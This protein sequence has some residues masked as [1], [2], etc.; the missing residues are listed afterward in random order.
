MIANTMPDP[1]Q[2]YAIR[3]EGL[4]KSFKGDS[5]GDQMPWVFA[6]VVGVKN[7]ILPPPKRVVVDNVNL[8]VQTGEFFGVLGSNGA[9]KT[10]LLKLLACLLYPDAG[11]GTVN[12]YDILKE[13]MSVRRSVTISKAQGGLG[14]LWQL[15]GRENLLFRARMSGLSNK[16]A[17]RK[18]DYIIERLGL[19]RK[20]RSYS[21]ELSSGEVQKF[22]LAATFISSAPIVMLDEPT[23]HLDPRVAREVREFIK[24]DLNK[25]GG[26]TIIMSTHYL[27]EADL[28]CDRVALMR[29]GQILACDTPAALKQ[30]YAPEPILEI[31]A[32]K[33][34]PEIGDQIKQKYGIAELLERFEDLATGQVRLRPKWAG[35]GGDA[36]AVRCELESRGVVI[37]SIK[38]VNSSLDDVYF[39]LTQEKL[40]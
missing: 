35:D 27:E 37:T 30:K 3:T 33:Y 28:L 6:T 1:S 8:A 16:E 20:A 32:S 22:T 9:G 36:D 19:G 21:W 23:S 17:V 2:R 4:T 13:R 34:A 10:T 15:S 39:R 31:R 29:K 40:K 12:G 14:L 25:A 24:Q 7:L 26:Q 5:G 38:N 18:V 11:G